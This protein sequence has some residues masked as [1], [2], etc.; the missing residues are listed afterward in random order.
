MKQV[1]G[2]LLALAG[3]G[4]GYM[5]RDALIKPER[6]RAERDG[7]GAA[8]AR[9]RVLASL[10]D[11]EKQRI[12]R[13]EFPELVVLRD[14]VTA[15]RRAAEEAET[16]AEEDRKAEAARRLEKFREMMRG[17]LKQ[18]ESMFSVNAR[19]A[20]RG[21]AGRM[22]LDDATIKKIAEAFDAEGT[23]AAELAM[24][25]ML[26]D[27]EADPDEALDA[28]MWFMGTAGMMSDELAAELGQFLSDDEIGT[29]REE[30]RVR[31]QQ[32]LERQAEM[33][34]RMMG[35]PDL[36]DRQQT[37]LKEMFSDG[38]MM[39]EQGRVWN[40]LM[41]EPEKMLA[42]ETDEDWQRILEPSLKSGRDRMR[43][44]LDDKQM[45]A[46]RRYEKQMIGQATMWIKPMLQ[47][48]KKQ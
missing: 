15:E 5:A 8:E 9:A 38:G 33:Q 24:G 31:N 6:T 36:S 1:I 48:A 23:R 45:E 46:Y 44:V 25:S 22:D 47:S 14:R 16:Q 2:L 28:F 42:A 21:I 43:G 13:T 18:W 4:L 12:L 10:T 35:I 37:E 27:T 17:Q 39:K 19:N 3:F 30:M 20:G 11:E 29:I 40:Q 32:Q 34:I 26:G 7:E 41:R